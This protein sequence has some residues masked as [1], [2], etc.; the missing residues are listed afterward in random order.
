LH[1]V[2][3]LTSEQP[4]APVR[5]HRFRSTA[6]WLPVAAVLLALLGL[7]VLL[8]Q[9]QP[10][11]LVRSVPLPSWFESALK[12]PQ[13][14]HLFYQAHVLVGTLFTQLGA[15]PS[16]AASEW[17]KAAWHARS[18]AE[19]EQAGRGLSQAVHR[20]HALELEASLCPYV[21]KWSE[22]SDVSEWGARGRQLAALRMA[23]LTCVE[24]AMFFG[25]VPDDMPIQYAANPP[26]SGLYHESPYPAYGVATAPVEPAMWL[27]NLA[28]GEIVLLYSCPA[29]CADVLARAEE[30]HRQLPP[31][32]NAR[33]GP[34]RFLIIASDT[35]DS[36]FAVVAWGHSLLLKQFDAQAIENFYI[37]LVDRGVECHFLVC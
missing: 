34:A 30:L 17:F 27:H 3:G 6:L 32:R 8:I 24:D 2:T 33:G 4:S 29:G 10:R 9:T 20:G 35:M 37:E 5:A 28:H 36:K 13:G 12:G 11:G 15:P 16:A 7:G 19:I 23:N 21:S 25:M 18:N 14:E 26:V 1:V 22:A 31:G